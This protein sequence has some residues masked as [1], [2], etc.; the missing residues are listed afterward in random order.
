MARHDSDHPADDAEVFEVA[1]RSHGPQLVPDAR[2]LM[3]DAGWDWADLDMLVFG[4]GPGAFTGLRIAAGLIQGLAAGIGCPV[5]GIETPRAIAARCLSAESSV[6]LAQVVQDARLGEIYTAR[7]QRDETHGALLLGTVQLCAP[8]SLVVEK[9]GV[10]CAGGNG[11]S[12][13]AE[14]QANVEVPTL[15]EQ[16]PHAVDLAHLAINDVRADERVLL[17]ARDALPFYV[18]DQVAQV[19]N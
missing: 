2:N 19:S 11:W 8:G 15:A 12:L 10:A 4:R 3:A 14:H 17:D 5:V 9:P 16:W 7:Y 18:R 1:P 6:D 13:V